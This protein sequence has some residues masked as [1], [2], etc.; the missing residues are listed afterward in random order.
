M[1]RITLLPWREEQ[2]QKGKKEFGL[3]LFGALLLAA[4]ATL[5][6]QVYY[7]QK[8]SDQN[9]RIQ[10]LNSEI[11]D[12]N[13]KIAEIDQLEAQKRRLLARMEVIEQLEATTPEAVILIDTLVDAIPAGTWLTEI[14]QQGTNVNLAGRA[15]SN[16]RVAEFL[17]NLDGSPWISGPPRLEEIINDGTGPIRDGRFNI[18]VTQV[19]L[20]D[21]QEAQ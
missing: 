2:R 4:G 6:T 3:A 20:T 17:R 7:Q 1:P 15:Q 14:R 9:Q 10:I 11:D 5:G 16:A 18:E 8:I 21:D 19:R 13:E 12:L